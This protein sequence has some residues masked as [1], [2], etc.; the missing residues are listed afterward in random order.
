MLTT[1]T[2][3]FLITVSVIAPTLVEQTKFP[4]TAALAPDTENTTK[5]GSLKQKYTKVMGKKLIKEGK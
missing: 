4:A 1:D 5:A 2:G 3:Q